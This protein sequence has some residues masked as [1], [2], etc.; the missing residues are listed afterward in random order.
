MT[1][2]NSMAERLIA[3]FTEH[4]MEKLFY[5]CLKKTGNSAEAEDLTQDI[6]LNILAALN[7]GTIPTS[8]SAWVWRIARNRYSVWADGKRRKAEAVAGADIGDYEIEDGGEDTLEAMI[9]REQLS[10]LRRELAFIGSEYRRVVVAYYIE[11]RSVREIAKS[12]SL[13][14]GAVKQRLYRA[15]TIL[16]EGMSM[17]R[18]FGVR[19]YRPEDVYYSMALVRLGEKNQPKSIMEHPLYTNIFLEAYGNPSS[20]EELSLELGVA[21]PYME[22]ELE[23]LTRE[24]FLIKK[25]GKYQTS[26]PIISR[27]AQ[28]QVHAER[29]TA[30]P[31][32][33]KALMNFVNRLNEAFTAQGY[34]Y[35][36]TY[37][38]YES[39]KWTFL[40]MAYQAF[41]YK[42]SNDYDFTERPDNGKWDIIGYPSCGMTQPPFVG[43][44]VRR[45]AKYF[46]QQFR[47]EFDGIA[48][49]TP[50]SLT[51]EEVR[52]LYDSVA[53]GVGE[54][55]AATA[56]KL[57][58]Y[59]YLRKA[60][61]ACEP[62][63][64]VM[65]SGEIKKAV[66]SMEEKTVSELTAL[67]D[68]ARSKLEKLYHTI[69]E[70]IRSDLPPVFSEDT[71]QCEL[72]V[73][74]S[75]YA[76]SYVM[77]EALR[78]GD[79]L[80]A[81]KVSRAVGAYIDLL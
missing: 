61:D 41:E 58:E 14:E 59:G 66:K 8:F 37:Q 29:Q 52:V 15:R 28:E 49:R 24:T 39:A 72:A 9:R 55:D 57:A 80:P 34:P 18:E 69:A 16:K 17:A 67:A 54:E 31:D 74:S 81:E 46:F 23:Y 19:S 20:A 11:D 12:L 45:G 62:A 33:T 10:L 53:G 36:G 27:S 71:R 47:Y 76:Y 65:N 22:Y 3:E 13:S 35:Y 21:L 32:I 26:F 73:S 60:G 43:N 63:I 1:E 40:M 5:F 77:A 25:D 64:L 51:E 42:A 68:D 38:D 79:L 56:E 7:K 44:Y 78:Q 4:Y 50:S 70:T 48:D 75:Y 30:A 6:A 2:T